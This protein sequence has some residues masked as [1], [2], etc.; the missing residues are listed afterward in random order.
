M[1]LLLTR[2]WI[3][4]W[5]CFT[6]PSKHRDQRRTATTLTAKVPLVSR[7]A[8]TAMNLSN[9]RCYRVLEGLLLAGAKSRGCCYGDEAITSPKSERLLKETDYLVING[10]KSFAPCGLSRDEIL[11]RGGNRWSNIVIEVVPKLLEAGLNCM[12]ITCL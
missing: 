5:N 12:L 7:S 4:S 3:L 6:Q 1:H 8:S 9:R 10:A 2:E 11:S